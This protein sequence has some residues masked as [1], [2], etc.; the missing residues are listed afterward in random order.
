M[1]YIFETERDEVLEYGSETYYIN[2]PYCGA[3]NI[4]TR[5][6]CA[7]PWG[8]DDEERIDCPKCGK[9]FEIRPKYK[10]EGFFIYTDDEQE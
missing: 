10:F 4:E 6:I 5:S 8:T 9:N 7:M 1:S 3:E 2:C